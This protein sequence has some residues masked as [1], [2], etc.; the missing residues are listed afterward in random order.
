MTTC[1]NPKVNIAGVEFDRVT[2]QGTLLQIETMI[3]SGRPHRIATAN[4]DFL[5]Q[6]ARDP[7]LAGILKDSDLVVCDG[8]PLVW[9]SRLLG[10]PLP[11][12][13]AGSDITPLLL[14]R[15]AEAG[16]RVFFLGGSDESL[17]KACENAVKR[18]PG[19]QIAGAYSPPFAPLDKMDDESIRAI[20]KEA[21]PDILLVSFGC[22]KQE[23]WIDR[24]YRELRVPV[25]IGV[26]AT[27]DF[28]AG[29]VRRAP[30]WMRLSGMEW[31]F[32]MLQEPKRLGPRY[33]RNIPFFVARVSVQSVQ[34]RSAAAFEKAANALA[35]LAKRIA[36]V[37][38]AIRTSSRSTNPVTKPSLT[39]TNG[40]AI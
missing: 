18:F 11:E 29:T 1:L 40:E 30:C 23:K 2:T 35:S 9:A 22:P 32:R 38:S 31:I 24:N 7:Q 25:C 12:R 27:I 13:V 26:G 15:A 33:L 6:A 4:A 14:Q 16:H 10:D 19:L 17:V 21:K 34:E 5:Y 3:R 8:T 28:L 36:N 20:V 37:A 39:L